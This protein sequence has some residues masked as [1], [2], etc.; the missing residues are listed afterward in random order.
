VRGALAGAIKKELGL[1]VL[2]EKT[3]DGRVYKIAGEEKA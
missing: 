2:S 1:K 3:E